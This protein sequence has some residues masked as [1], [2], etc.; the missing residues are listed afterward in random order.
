M[1][2]IS[3]EENREE[4]IGNEKITRIRAFRKFNLF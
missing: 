1:F 3:S 4:I 2:E